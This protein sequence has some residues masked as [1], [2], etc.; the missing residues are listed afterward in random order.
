MHSGRQRIWRRVLAVLVVGLLY[1]TMGQP[2]AMAVA[3]A[4]Q[5]QQQQQQKAQPELRVVI[6]VSGS[7]KTHDPER[8]AAT[9][10]ELLVTLL[11]RQA[12]AGVWTFGEGVD[13]PL[14]SAR[15]SE[16]WR[17]QALRLS[18]ALSDY[19]Q[20]TDIEAAVAEASEGASQHPRHLLL[21]TDGMVDLPP[22]Q[23]VKSEVN[24]E[25]RRRLVDE[26]APRLAREG[27]TIHAIAFSAEADLALVEQ[28][29]R[30]TGGLAS[31]VDSADGLLGA[32]VDIAARVFPGD[33]E[34][35]LRDGRFTLDSSVNEISVL[36]LHEHN[37][38]VTLIDPQGRR[39]SADKPPAGS[40][41]Q[42][43]PM[44]DLIRVPDPVAG[45]WRLEGA[46][47]PQSRVTVEGDWQLHVAALPATLYR[48]FPL[49]VTAWLAKQSDADAA[50]P[51]DL[52]VQV[53]LSASGNDA[54]GESVDDGETL[55]LVRGEEGRFHGTLP[56]PRRLGNA[57]LVIIAEAGTL[58]RQ[59]RR[60]V[61]ILP[62]IGMRHDARGHGVEL[63][64]E[65][66]ELDHDNTQIQGELFG[67]TLLAEASAPKRWWLALPE[68]DDTLKRPLRLNASVALDGMR[69]DIA[70]PVL[71]LNS[72]GS[73][74][75]DQARFGPTLRGEALA[76]E[77]R[78]AV[79]ESGEPTMA[80]R[81]VSWINAAPSWLRTQW[82]HGFPALRGWV[83]RYRSYPVAWATLAIVALL[84]F[85]F[86]Y[87]RRRHGR[88]RVTHR[89]DP[90]V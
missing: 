14:P 87:W 67:E 85:V 62:T 33:D 37:G 11:P 24:A 49:E 30:Q 21:L 82:Q 31:Q 29:A 88:I 89:E 4:Q 41:W 38:S 13:N 40:R 53:S 52:S 76:A 8:L 71:W 15:A 12:S 7:M 68:L 74:S 63:V 2:A 6:D 35:A 61:N 9:A 75:I 90:H 84:W 27:V 26:L 28:L 83:E 77:S 20:Y 79:D 17:R 58:Q 51:E 43:E 48:G 69:F 56:G 80:D 72:D 64:A 42:V 54:D 57:E 34:V 81:F 39:Y 60:A 10:L 19:Q 3:S 78:T 46:L 18:P 55:R 32:F 16:G 70:L 36:A 44:F 73:V 47:S 5:Q 66:P 50:A 59:R 1:M 45:E 22:G 23:G 65:H 25:S 86:I